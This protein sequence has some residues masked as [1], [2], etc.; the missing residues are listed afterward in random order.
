MVC[1]WIHLITT[2]SISM[3][4]HWIRNTTQVDRW[5]MSKNNLIKFHW[6][7]SLVSSWDV[8]KGKSSS[9]SDTFSFFHTQIWTSNPDIGRW[10]NLNL[11][12]IYSIIGCHN[13]DTFNSFPSPLFLHQCTC[14]SAHLWKSTLCPWSRTSQSTPPISFLIWYLR[15]LRVAWNTRP[16]VYCEWDKWW[17]RHWSLHS[18]HDLITSLS[19]I[20]S[21]SVQ[22][23]WL[24][25]IQAWWSWWVRVVFLT[26]ISQKHAAWYILLHPHTW[27]NSSDPSL[28][29]W[30][31]L[32]AEVLNLLCT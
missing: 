12:T 3:T 1:C 30:Q 28:Q 10:C 29:M 5:G 4:I 19:Y 11:S 23:K 14:I 9:T 22:K 15:W 25:S 20:Q 16:L 32:R 7:S 2:L 31:V 24:T 13:I 8:C 27:Y 21:H 6:F 18:R 26:C 17:K